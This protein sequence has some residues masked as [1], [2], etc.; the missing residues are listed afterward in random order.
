MT[1][2]S[3]EH[4]PPLTSFG[5]PST[6]FEVGRRVTP[7]TLAWSRGLVLT[8][9]LLIVVGF[10]FIIPQA[11]VGGGIILV[12]GLIWLVSGWRSYRDARRLERRSGP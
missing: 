1:E 8:G 3:E 10:A 11:V 9:V 7:W 2:P 6:P 5:L 12:L 4:D